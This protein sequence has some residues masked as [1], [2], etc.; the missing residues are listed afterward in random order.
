[1]IF[2]QKSYWLEVWDYLNNEHKDIHKFGSKEQGWCYLSYKYSR[3]KITY[4]MDFPEIKSICET[5]KLPVYE[6]EKLHFR[7]ISAKFHEQ[8]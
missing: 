7:S 4:Q 6:F 5:L 1:M 3:I 8:N 2:Q